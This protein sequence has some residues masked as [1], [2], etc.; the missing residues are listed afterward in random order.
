[1]A[2]DQYGRIIEDGIANACEGTLNFTQIYNLVCDQS[3]STVSKKTISRWL[4]KLIEGEII[5]KDDGPRIRN[6]VYY[7]L[8]SARI[9][10][11]QLFPK[12][13]EESVLTSNIEGQQEADKKACILV[14]L[15]AALDTI[16]P[17]FTD[18]PKLGAIYCY[19]PAAG[20]SQ[21]LIGDKLTGVTTKEV[22]EH[23]NIGL[24]GLFDHVNFTQLLRKAD[25]VQ[26]IQDVLGF[27]N[28][29]IRRVVRKDENEIAIKINHRFL[30]DF[31]AMC[32]CLTTWIHSRLRDT[33]TIA[34]LN[35]LYK[36][37]NLSDPPPASFFSK[38]EQEA[39]KS[40]LS[41][42]GR[43]KLDYE[44][45]HSKEKFAKLMEYVE[46]GSSNKKLS[47]NA[48]KKKV[49]EYIQK[50]KDEILQ[51][52]KNIIALY[53]GLIKCERYVD[54]PVLKNTTGMTTIM[55]M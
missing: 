52:D 39:F 30:N 12:S 40:Y 36:K 17:K 19:Y 46:Q 1:M 20:R 41:L 48:I 33:I 3:C 27:E 23:T 34:L 37:G 32:A 45:K 31:I 49:R 22:L 29:T 16:S 47:K 25:C 8:T 26:T 50:R 18:E 44:L 24:G 11:R 10:E 43:G 42:Y 21:C 35:V 54:A 55:T 38:F 15:Q 2:E 28:D 53:Y 7:S 6:K 9:F 13:K 14:L 4:V 51:T 5:Q